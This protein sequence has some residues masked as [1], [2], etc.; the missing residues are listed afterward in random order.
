VIPLNPE[1]FGIYSGTPL[2]GNRHNAYS[3]PG[4][5]DELGHPFLKA[6]DCENATAPA[7][8]FAP[9]CVPQGPFTFNG[10]TGDYPQVHRAP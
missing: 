9:P 10:F 4:Y 1:G 3:K 2:P 8:G 7:L 5:L 6:F